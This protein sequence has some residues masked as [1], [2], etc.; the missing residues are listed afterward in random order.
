YCTIVIVLSLGDTGWTQLVLA[1]L[2]IYA[3]PIID[4]TLAIARRK[5]SGK[6]IS[7]AD[8][9]HLH[10]MLK[11]A[12]GVKGAVLALYAIAGGFAALGVLMSLERA[13]VVYS[14]A[15][16]FAAFIVVIA[17]KIAHRK[18]LEEQT[19]AL[20]SRHRSRAPAHP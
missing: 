20:T 10:H 19:V 7:D 3:L 17:I 8:D 16:V 4:T 11:R 9:Q 2:V 1:G 15:F 6:R 12:L 5:V 14:I 13:R 18:Q